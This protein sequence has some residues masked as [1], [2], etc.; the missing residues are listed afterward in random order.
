MSTLA[1]I[2]AA[3]ERLP[4]PEQRQLVAQLTSKPPVQPRT[5]SRAEREAWMAELAELARRSSTGRH[6][7]STEQILDELREERT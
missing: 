5:L 1:E 4:L 3:A 7:I 6:S 2:A